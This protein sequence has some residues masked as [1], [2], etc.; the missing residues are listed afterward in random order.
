MRDAR[1]ASRKTR[2]AAPIRRREK[3]CCRLACAPVLA[4]RRDRASDRCVPYVGGRRWPALHRASPGMAGC[5]RLRHQLANAAFHDGAQGALASRCLTNRRR[6]S[7]GH[8][9]F[10]RVS[11]G[12]GPA[13]A[14]H[15]R[16]PLLLGESPL[17]GCLGSLRWA[18]TLWDVQCMAHE[19]GKPLLGGLLV[20]LLTP[21]RACDDSNVPHRIQPRR[22]SSPKP[23]SLLVR[24]NARFLEVPQELDSSRRRVH[25]LPPR[26]ARS[27]RSVL[28][29]RPRNRNAG[30][31][32]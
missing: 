20:L 6:L 13:F 26:S 2:A 10:V 21:S 14:F 3:H 5:G 15:F 22:Q 1:R 18:T 29:L 23:S 12:V 4:L 27:G 7:D 25:M 24:E 9:E 31:D 16:A 28:Q 30:R 8:V 32:V 11:V 19:R 17:V